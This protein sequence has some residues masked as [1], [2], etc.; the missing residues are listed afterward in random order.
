MAVQRLAFAALASVLVSIQASPGVAQGAALDL[1]AANDNRQ[2][3]GKIADGVLTV[4]LVAG[5]GEWRPEVLDGPVLAVAAFGGEGGDLMIPGP[6]IRAAEDT[7]IVVRVH[8]TLPD[9]IVVHGFLTRPS[10]QETPWRVPAGETGEIRFKTGEPGTYHYWATTS[11]CENSVA[12]AHGRRQ[13]VRWRAHRRRGERHRA[14]S[15]LRH[16]R[17]GRQPHPHRRVGDAGR[18]TRVRHQRSL[19]AAHR[20][21]GRTRWRAR[22][23]AHREPHA[24]GSPHAPARLLFRCTGRRDGIRRDRIPA[25]DIRKVV[26]EN[27]AIGGT[28]QMAWTPERPGNWLLHCHLIA[29]VTPALRFWMTEPPKAS[30]HVSHGSHDPASAMAGL[31]M[32]IRVTGDV[33]HAAG[34]SGTVAPARQLTMAMRK[35]SGYWQP[36]DAYG[37]ALTSGENVDASH[38]PAVP[39]PLL[40]LRRDSPSRSR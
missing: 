2:S 35:K 38:G 28:M 11:D 24:S 32:G 33:S 34:A 37:F 1:I 14:R 9:E 15:R 23:M 30:D 18:S 8:N 13:P 12:R 27:M 22:A 19:V 10:T 39:G 40:V 5:R 3:A 36:E 25:A 21:A 6:L 29:H 20:T 7:D 31:V 16:D 26:T 4:N 17:V